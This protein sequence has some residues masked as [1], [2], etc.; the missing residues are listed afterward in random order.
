MLED[1]MCLCVDR[2]REG[3][4]TF[5]RAAITNYY[6]LGDLQQKKFLSH[7]YGD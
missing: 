2:F 3:E 4:D 5:P 6:R 1:A 7:G